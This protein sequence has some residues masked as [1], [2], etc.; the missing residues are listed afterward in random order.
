MR[1]GN[2]EGARRSCL[3]CYYRIND[4][5]NSAYVRETTTLQVA[6][7]EKIRPRVGES[8]AGEIRDNGYS[9]LPINEWMVRKVKSVSYTHLTLP[10]KA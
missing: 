9:P 5:R 1:R 7:H 4:D 6:E 8:G 10:T 3:A 2:V